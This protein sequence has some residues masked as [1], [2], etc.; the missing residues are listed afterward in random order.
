MECPILGCAAVYQSPNGLYSHLAKFDHSDFV[1]EQKVSTMGHLFFD[2]IHNVVVCPNTQTVI[3]DGLW[4]EHQMT[5]EKC[6][7]YSEP[8]PVLSS[9]LPVF[10]REVVQG[11]KVQKGNNKKFQVINGTV[12]TITLTD[13]NRPYQISTSGSSAPDP[14][15]PGILGEL[16][17]YLKP[18]LL[19]F[20][21]IS[22]S[23]RCNAAQDISTTNESILASLANTYFLSS[24]LHLD[25]EDFN[26]FR[27]EIRS[28]DN[29][30]Q[31]PLPFQQL[32]IKST[33]QSYMSIFAK[34]NVYM[35]RDLHS[36]EIF[37][38]PESKVYS[39]FVQLESMINEDESLYEEL[40]TIRLQFLDKVRDIH[41][42]EED[43]EN[44]EDEE[45]DTEE[46]Y[47]FPVERENTRHLM[48]RDR[49]ESHIYNINLNFDTTARAQ[50][51]LAQFHQLWC[52]LILEESRNKTPMY[53]Q[54]IGFHLRS[55]KEGSP[56]SVDS[57]NKAC[58]GLLYSMRLII[59][60]DLI[61]RDSADAYSI[62]YSLWNYSL[63]N[64]TGSMACKHFYALSKSVSEAKQNQI[65]HHCHWDNIADP[66]EIIFPSGQSLKIERL[67]EGIANWTSELLNDLDDL[68]MGFT[69]NFDIKDDIGDDSL[70]YNCFW[71]NTDLLEDYLSDREIEPPEINSYVARAQAWLKSFLILSRLS[72]PGA[73]RTTAMFHW[74]FAN[75]TQ[76]RNVCIEDDLCFFVCSYNKTS[77][78]KDHQ[79]MGKKLQLY[80]PTILK[81]MLVR[82]LVIV[83]QHI[84]IAMENVNPSFKTRL[85]SNPTGP[86]P[87]SLLQR[88]H[89]KL[90]MKYLDLKLGCNSWRHCQEII[91]KSLNRLVA[92]DISLQRTLSYCSNFLDHT[93]ATGQKFYGDNIHYRYDVDPA[94]RNFARGIATVY[95]GFLGYDDLNRTNT[96]THDV[97]SAP[98]ETSMEVELA[99]TSKR[100]QF[101]QPDRRESFSEMAYLLEMQ[102][103]HGMKETPCWNSIAQMRCT[104]LA[105][106]TNQ[107][108]CAILPT[109]G[110]KTLIFEMPLYFESSSHTIIVVPFISLKEDLIQRLA[111]VKIPVSPTTNDL[112]KDNH[113]V[114]IVTY[115]GAINIKAKAGE[116]LAKKS[117][118]RIIYDECHTLATDAPF[119]NEV[120]SAFGEFDIQKIFLTA[121]LPP[122]YENEIQKYANTPLEFIR[123]ETNRPN[124]AYTVYTASNFWAAY[125]YLVMVAEDFL[126]HFAKD[127]DK[128]MIVYIPQKVLSTKVQEVLPL[129]IKSA[130]FFGEN[131]REE[132]S[133]L[134]HGFISGEYNTMIATTAFSTGIDY[135]KVSH[136]V[137]WDSISSMIEFV[138]SSGRAGR[139]GSPAQSVFIRY[140]NKKTRKTSRTDDDY[141]PS[142]T[143]SAESYHFSGRCRRFKISSYIDGTPFTCS[144]GDCLPCDHCRSRTNE[145]WII[146]DAYLRKLERSDFSQYNIR[147]EIL[148]NKFA[149]QQL[150][151][152]PQRALFAKDAKPCGP[153]K[154]VLEVFNSQI[155]KKFHPGCCWACG[156]KKFSSI[157]Q[158]QRHESGSAYERCEF[159]HA[160]QETLV[161][162]YYVFE[163][164]E[165]ISLKMLGVPNDLQKIIRQVVKEAEAFMADGKARSCFDSAAVYG[166]DLYIVGAALTVIYIRLVGTDEVTL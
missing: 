68:T 79:G 69:C 137:H 19:E 71:N 50:T 4:H 99:Q 67:R 92:N 28:R 134:F 43:G 22:P 121:T 56:L 46:E 120:H 136:V 52:A 48:P 32:T 155:H 135:P 45:D 25:T 38:W 82:Y 151:Y 7:S 77:F 159:K 114:H 30:N 118:R 44:E 165:K 73:P 64:E 125:G 89:H 166:G 91:F 20:Q 96:Q 102:K 103:R 33:V 117:L 101:S 83:A 105:I 78:K 126:N 129:G 139:D 153:E 141:K 162:C 111:A 94:H 57:A 138:Q 23:I 5:C 128:R 154:L 15:I 149:N 123:T 97:F 104:Q 49:L 24:Y 90:T 163:K 161:W 130:E 131:T 164:N 143:F 47:M 85:C 37:N 61:K 110:G 21:H 9:V 106:D 127:Q 55:G 3:L 6:Q 70:G 62:A 160:M 10:P 59:W 95:H 150:F 11:I 113:L 81:D 2:K 100:V 8:L 142:N 54:A 122:D 157:L 12:R 36:K 1:D 158:I 84:S 124:I 58:C 14:V 17:S 51:V 60:R 31:V 29:V 152:C 76:I 133:K 75:T 26:R 66:T 35:L 147:Y 27:S 74:T 88:E 148:R 87:V 156:V 93:Q 140:E 72:C 112:Y 39:L 119:R 109:G 144:I 41:Q 132:K 146:N 63:Y 42:N 53:F 116:W 86:W 145:S 80:I 107:S 108:F 13:I 18:K 40:E 65:R 98:Q 16:P 34:I 115:E